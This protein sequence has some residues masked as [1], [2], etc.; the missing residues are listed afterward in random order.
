MMKLPKRHATPW[1]GGRLAPMGPHTHAH[2]ARITTHTHRD[3]PP[4]P[5]SP[6]RHSPSLAVF[7]AH[8]LLQVDPFV[9]RRSD[10]STVTRSPSHPSPILPG[11][12]SMVVCGL[13][14][15]PDDTDHFP[16]PGPIGIVKIPAIFPAKSGRDGA[17]R[18][19][20]SGIWGSG[21][22][23]VWILLTSG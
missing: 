21:Y 22:Y 16:D 1:E 20:D 9:S 13:H 19:P 5:V 18:A 17:A 6:P 8:F 7:N 11:R 2:T 4:L 10:P 14:S 3:A 23:S 15:A 12:L